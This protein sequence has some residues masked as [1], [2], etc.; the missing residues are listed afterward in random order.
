MSMV[1]R[2]S[3]SSTAALSAPERKRD[4]TS[5]RTGQSAKRSRKLC[6]CCCAS[7]VVGTSTATWRP[8]STPAKAAATHGDEG[9]A[10][11]H[12][13]LA[14]A[15]VAADHAVHGLGGLHV[16]EHL[17]HGL[18]L[19]RGLLEWEAVG[20]ALVLELAGVQRRRLMRRAAGAPIEQLGGDV[21]YRLA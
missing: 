16:L 21:A 7:S 13:G 14:K 11:R 9:G 17:A 20:K 19:V 1:P 8:V 12:L 2:C 18:G 5:M 3:P 4:S 15:D 6:S 10:H